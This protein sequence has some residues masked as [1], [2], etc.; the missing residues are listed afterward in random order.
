MAQLYMNGYPIIYR[1]NHPRC[2]HDG[3]IYQHIEVAENKIGRFLR[4]GEVVHHRDQ[5]R[6]NNDPSNLLIF[7]SKSDHTSF[8]QH[9][10]DESLLK[11]LDDGTYTI[12]YLKKNICPLCGNQKAKKN[13]ICWNCRQALGPVNKK[14]N[15]LILT[16]E[17]LKSLI[18]TMPFT[19]IGKEFNVTDNAIR[20]W[21]DKYKLPRT[22]KEINKYTDEEWERI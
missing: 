22:K 1:P 9:N 2:N 12:N 18:R 10:C 8:H 15:D 4:Y 19:Q 6:S 14:V 5:N 7:S 16:R 11:Q 20:K 21:C 17:L 3:Y 13:D